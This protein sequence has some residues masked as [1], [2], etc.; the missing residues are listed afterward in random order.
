MPVEHLMTKMT[1]VCARVGWR[2]QAPEA[3]SLEQ[4]GQPDEGSLWQACH[5]VSLS[6]PLPLLPF[7]SP[8]SLFPPR[9]VQSQP[10]SDKCLPY[11]VSILAAKFLKLSHTLEASRLYPALAPPTTTNKNK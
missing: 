1:G 9:L 8:S 7:P 11:S 3:P 6:L 5:P 2:W 10:I 4:G